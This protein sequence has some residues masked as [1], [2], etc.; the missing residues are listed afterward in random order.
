MIDWHVAILCVIGFVVWWRHHRDAAVVVIPFYIAETLLW[1][2]V[3]ERRVILVLPVILAFYVLGGWAVVRFLLAWARER[4]WR[5]WLAPVGLSILATARGCRSS[6]RA[7]L[8]G[9]PLRRRP[10]ELEAGRLEVHGHV[11]GPRTP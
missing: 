3:N 5:P 8:A 11:V 4:R 9:L 7:V 2:N 1:P 6:G 10:G